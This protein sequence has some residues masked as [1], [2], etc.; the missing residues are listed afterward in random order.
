MQ[1]EQRRMPVP[2]SC[3][4]QCLIAQ[5]DIYFR[6]QSNYPHLL[7]QRAGILLEKKS[8]LFKHKFVFI[9]HLSFNIEQYD[10]LLQVPVIWGDFAE[11]RIKQGY[12]SV[13]RL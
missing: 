13:S 10:S 1:R 5:G 7:P 2:C 8:F 11:G 3:P 12:V 4:W 9:T 6:T